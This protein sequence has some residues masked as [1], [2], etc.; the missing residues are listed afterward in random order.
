MRAEQLLPRLMMTATLLVAALIFA[1][2][3]AYAHGGHSH[4][5][6]PSS[7]HRPLA[8]PGLRT[9]VITGANEAAARSIAHELG[10]EPVFVQVPPHEKAPKVRELQAEGARVAFV[11]DGINDAPALAQADLGIAMGTGTGIAIEAG[12]V[13]LVKGSPLKIVEALT[14]SR[15]TFRTI[16]QN[17]FWAFFYNAAAIPLGALGWLNPMMR[18]P[19]WRSPVSAWWPTACASNASS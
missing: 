8:Q 16:R 10:I 1:P 7:R 5:V 19:S 11:G 15:L 4:D 9:A 14:L 3:G 6:Q 2:A 13:V 18:A 17:L 12:N